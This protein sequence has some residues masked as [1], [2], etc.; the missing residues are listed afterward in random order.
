MRY[1]VGHHTVETEQVDNS[2][3]TPGIERNIRH[4][5]AVKVNGQLVDCGFC[6]L[7]SVATRRRMLVTNAAVTTLC[8][9]T[10]IDYVIA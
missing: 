9:V 6:G 10:G 8:K 2:V 1:K 5:W 3:K 7:A 4:Y